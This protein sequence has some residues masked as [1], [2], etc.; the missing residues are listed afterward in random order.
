MKRKNITEQLQFGLVGCGAIGQEHIRNLA[1][2]QLKTE[3]N[4]RLIACCDTNEKIRSLARK[5]AAKDVKIY[6]SYKKMLSEEMSMNAIIVA[7]PNWHHIHI[8][9]DLLGE[10]AK[11]RESSKR[12]LLHILCEKPLCTNVKDCLEVESMLKRTGYAQGKA[13]FW[14][15]MEYRFIPSVGR[16]ISEIDKGT[17]GMPKMV[18]IREHRFP[19]LMKVDNWNRFA[20]NTGGTLVEKCCH[21]FDLSARMLREQKPVRVF[22]TGAQDVNHLD[23][24]LKGVGEGLV[25]DIIDNAFTVVD[26]SNGSRSCLDLC[27]FA[28]ASQNQE[29]ISVVGSKG[30]IEAHAPAHGAITSADQDPPN[31]LIG[32]RREWK[33]RVDPPP[34]PLPL[35]KL[36]VHAPLDVQKAGYHAG[37][38][39]FELKAFYDAIH[40]GEPYKATV[41]V[42]DGTL[43]VAIGQAAHISIKESRAVLMSELLGP[44]KSP[45]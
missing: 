25:P 28:E 35:Q 9:R 19:F 44:G 26:W 45:L 40:R 18:H 6:D 14:V 20:K 8:L 31:V 2:L 43:A 42:R 34:P 15:G 12:P 38:T 37:A 22:A 27:M 3:G 7:T 16:L 32:T 36:C 33:D 24:K 1:L 21:F 13:M 11:A 5:N 41:D 23:E 4:V 30:K 29:E 39:Y 10:D 17:V